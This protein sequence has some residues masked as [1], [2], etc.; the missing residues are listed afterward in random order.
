M[1]DIFEDI[2]A[3]YSEGKD[4]ALATVVDTWRSAPRM[5]GSA[6][7]IA[8]DMQNVGS[9]SGG[10]VEGSVIK[11]ALPLIQSGEGKLIRFG[12]SNEEAWSVG[13]SCGGK[14][15]VYVERFLGLSEKERRVWET[16]QQ[17]IQDNASSILV[18]PLVDGIS[19]HSLLLPGGEV[20][21]HALPEAL[22]QQAI[23]SARMRKHQVVEMGDTSYFI[24]LF[25]KK[26]RMIIVGA[27][28][29]SLDLIDLANQFDF[30][31]IVIEPRG[32]FTQ[33]TRF[34][35]PPHQLHQTWP[36]EVLADMA[37]DADTYAV[38]LTHDPKIDD[39][40][41]HHLLRSEVAY[42][43]ALGSSKTHA[44]RVGRLEKAGFSEAEIARIHGPVGVNIRALSPKEIALSIMAQIIQVKNQHH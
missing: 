10:C 17:R 2:K 19:Q 18:T 41:L 27:A 29:V 11:E 21:G 9:V 28:H 1:K 37:I 15:K 43:G 24:Q 25:P 4:F 30:E 40:A 14:I 20:I 38:M 12:V 7:A 16:L 32:V 44:K 6:M 35:S 39:Q 8:Q 22:V 26:A 33:E 42:I 36:E 34:K 31:T 23:E 3:W 5:V 13:L